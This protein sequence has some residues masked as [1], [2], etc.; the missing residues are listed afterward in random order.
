MFIG[1]AAKEAGGSDED[2]A[3]RCRDFAAAFERRFGP[4]RCAVLRPE[5]F[6]PANPPHLCEG[7]TREALAFAIAF[8]SDESGEAD[9]GAG[10]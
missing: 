9:T 3:R 2:A 6:D 4:L 10:R 1:V 7:L 5:G 8:L